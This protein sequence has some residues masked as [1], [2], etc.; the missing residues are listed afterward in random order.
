MY[1]NYY[2]FITYFTNWFFILYELFM[3][4]RNTRPYST[5]SITASVFEELFTHRLDPDKEW[6]LPVRGCPVIGRCDVYLALTAAPAP[7]AGSSSVGTRCCPSCVSW[8]APRSRPCD[9]RSHRQT[10]RVK[11]K[12]VWGEKQRV[13]SLTLRLWCHTSECTRPSGDDDVPALRVLLGAK[14][15]VWDSCH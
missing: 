11:P 5:P 14:A 9:R 12:T 10:Y 1:L 2:Q 6:A 8:E 3:T 4:F 7:G 13:T 15:S